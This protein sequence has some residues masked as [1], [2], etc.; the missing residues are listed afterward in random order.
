[1][2]RDAQGNHIPE[3]QEDMEAR[4]NHLP[5]NVE[6]FIPIPRRQ[7]AVPVR[8]RARLRVLSADAVRG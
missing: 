1:M 2:E 3:D 5:E 7:M 8:R 6:F 4:F